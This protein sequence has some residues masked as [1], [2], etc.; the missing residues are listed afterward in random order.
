MSGRFV[1]FL[2]LLIFVLN[3]A[4]LLRS[5]II[6]VSV[7]QAD[8]KDFVIKRDIFSPLKLRPDVQPKQIEP[9]IDEPVKEEEQKDET[10]AEAM[11]AEI[12]QN[13]SFEGYVIKYKKNHALLSINGE[14]F[15]AAEADI[16]LEKIKIV[17]IEKKEL[18]VE[19]DAN[20]Y[21]IKLKGDDEDEAQ[22]Q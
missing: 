6:K 21:K 7:L 3:S 19:V 10:S 18:T 17:K 4:A 9:I 14:F 22:I 15:V 1:T 2:V 11:A 5:E 8:K 16:V 12:K 13:I 20:I